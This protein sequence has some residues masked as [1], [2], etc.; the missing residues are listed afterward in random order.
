MNK[1]N[2]RL[3]EPKDA[4]QY[5][6]WLKAD[7]KINY[8]DPATVNYRSS[9]TAVVEKHEDGKEPVPVLIQTANPVL[10]LEAIAPNPDN[11]PMQ[12]A[13]AINEMFEAFK[14]LAT[15]YGIKELY[16]CSSHEPLQK[17][18][19]KRGCKRVTLPVYR[20]TL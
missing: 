17:M 12:N 9:V 3:A 1:S 16:F 15:A 2:V 18:V 5:A 11:T 14:R 20:F 10:M 6:E 19:E 4:K 13:R 8:V 7:A